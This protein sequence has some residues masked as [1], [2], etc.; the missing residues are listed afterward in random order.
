M[1]A[2]PVAP[3]RVLPP[4]DI[5]RF[6][7]LIASPAWRDDKRVPFAAMCAVSR[8]ALFRMLWSGVRIGRTV[9]PDRARLRGR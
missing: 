1:F 3:P 4:R 8:L 7:R 6:W 9:H 2:N 5:L